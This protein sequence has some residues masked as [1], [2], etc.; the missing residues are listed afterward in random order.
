MIV[1]Y[2]RNQHWQRL[3]DHNHLRISRIIRSTKLLEQ[4]PFSWHSR[5]Y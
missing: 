2:E 5:S 4:I 3:H 1:F